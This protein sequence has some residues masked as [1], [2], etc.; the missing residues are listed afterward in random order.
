MITN[1]SDVFFKL[2]HAKIFPDPHSDQSRGCSNYGCNGVFLGCHH[3]LVYHWWIQQWWHIYLHLPSITYWNKYYL[4][5]NLLMP[6]FMAPFRNLR[7]ASNKWVAIN[8]GIKSRHQVLEISTWIQAACHR[9]WTAG[10]WTLSYS[11]VFCW[12]T[13]W[14]NYQSANVSQPICFSNN[15]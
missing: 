6:S 8:D 12:R 2:N 15:F 3:Q 5:E 7:K 13:S 1:T 14:P 10:G 9:N 11:Q 4:F